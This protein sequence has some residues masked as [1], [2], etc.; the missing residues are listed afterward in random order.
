[1]GQWLVNVMLNSQLSSIYFDK[2]KI[3]K[4]VPGDTPISEGMPSWDAD[5]LLMLPTV[6]DFHV[7]LD[8]QFPTNQWISR[9]R[10]SSILEQFRLEK[11]LLSPLK[12]GQKDRAKQ[13]L[14]QMLN[15]GTTSIRV[16]VDI[17]PEIGLS[18]LETVMQLK[19]EYK[20]KME[21]EIVAFPQQGLLRSASGLWIKQA[22]KEGVTIVGGVDP[23]GVDRDIEGCLHVIFDIS[24]QFGAE[25]DIHLHDPGD[26]GLFTIERIADYTE[27]TRMQG[28]VTISHAYCLGEISEHASAEIAHRL[29]DQRISVITSVPID[30]PMPRVEQLTS[31]G[32]K[33]SLGTDH[34]GL[35]A[36]TPFGCADLL[37]RGRRL[38][39]INRWNDDERLRA[40]YPYLSACLQFQ[41]G[42]RADFMLLDAL[43][44]EHAIA[45]APPRE[46]VAVQGVPVA[47]RRLHEAWN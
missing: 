11:H 46:I 43:N 9:P 35:D 15:F 13:T 33:I 23:G 27:Q 7:H 19:E 25:V 41:E 47:G 10:V 18:H 5:G 42:D 20:N 37:S 34:T 22:M 6:K 32:V 8:K 39:E 24:T 38:A 26:L 21:M 29:A 12:S 1:L 16:H 36:W 30:S 31:I 3:V 2:G 28:R 40:V 44:P 17:D 14:D 4:I 45:A